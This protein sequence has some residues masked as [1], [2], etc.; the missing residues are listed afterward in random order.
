MRGN[1][2]IVLI[3]SSIL[4]S[5]AGAPGPRSPA[6]R[7]AIRKREKAVAAADEAWGKAI[8]AADRSVLKDLQIAHKTVMAANDLDEAKAIAE[9]LTIFQAELDV[10][11]GERIK[12]TV[13]AKLDWQQ[14][15]KLPK[16][17][18]D[19]AARGEWILMAGKP[20]GAD[21]RP[22]SKGQGALIGRIDGQEMLLGS[23]ATF[24]VTGEGVVEMKAAD[25]PASLT[26]NSGS[27][28]VTLRRRG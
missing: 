18:Y 2:S 21:G 8:A 17:M 12:V 27:I 5:A 1:T 15:A 28:E 14:V 9:R 24:T 3:L 11:D 23:K 26:D 13:S 6:A 19:V 10:L 22:G 4:S 20:W 16:G 25:D 7:E